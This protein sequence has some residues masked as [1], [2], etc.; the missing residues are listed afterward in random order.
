MPF[1]K[2]YQ[3]EHIIG[4]GKTKICP[5]NA[6]Q[7][8]LWFNHLT[9]PSFAGAVEFV[10]FPANRSRHLCSLADFLG[11]RLIEQVFGVNFLWAWIVIEK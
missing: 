1:N 5:L 3:A 9:T 10:R 6:Y 7:F 11:P 8:A 2:L 4:A